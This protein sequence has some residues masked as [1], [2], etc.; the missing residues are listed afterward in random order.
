MDY[1]LGLRSHLACGVSSHASE[2]QRRQG[3]G[4]MFLTPNVLLQA[5]ILG[6]GPFSVEC[7]RAK[8]ETEK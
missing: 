2:P 1:H 6:F 4:Q 8:G 3:K 7:F 5:I